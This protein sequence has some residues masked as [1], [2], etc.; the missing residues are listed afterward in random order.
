M[1]R[2]VLRTAAKRSRYT[3]WPGPRRQSQRRDDDYE[4]PADYHN[5]RNHAFE[6]RQRFAPL[7]QQTRHEFTEQGDGD[8]NS[9]AQRDGRHIEHTGGTEQQK[10]T[11]YYASHQRG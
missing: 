8:D 4:Y 6:G 7:A 3:R 9:P 10:H 5:Q 2:A 11:G 1:P